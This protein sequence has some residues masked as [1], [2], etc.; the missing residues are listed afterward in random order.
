MKL[1][2]VA[3]RFLSQEILKLVSSNTKMLTLFLFLVLHKNPFCFVV[4]WGKQLLFEIQ[5]LASREGP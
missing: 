4:G 1:L 3:V 5:A 2:S